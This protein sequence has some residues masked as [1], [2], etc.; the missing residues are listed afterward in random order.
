MLLYLLI[1][2]GGG[3]GSVTRFWLSEMISARMD[4]PF[5]W[6]T[7]VVNLTGCFAIGLLAFYSG[8]GGRHFT[9][10]E[11]RFL[12]LTG[13]C[14]GYTTFSAFSL[15]TLTLLRSG[16]TGRAAAYVVVSVALCLLGTWLGYRL[17]SG[18]I[19]QR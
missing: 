7:L 14:G 4:S 2:L 9:S 15:Q 18:W 8:P 1:A 10:Q 5:P 13:F 12:L 19:A 17:G 16:D 3:L 11:G 6:G